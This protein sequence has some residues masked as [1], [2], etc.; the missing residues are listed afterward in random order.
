[1][2]LPVAAILCATAATYIL[3]ALAAGY[4]ARMGF[5]MPKD[6]RHVGCINGLRGYL[7]LS[8]L[9]H[10]F[11]IWILVSRTTGGWAPPPSPILA[12]FGSSSVA[13]FF[14]V[15]G[16]VFYPRVLDGWRNVAWKTL[17]T[18]RLFRIV[19]LTVVCV[20]VVV[21]IILARQ[22]M[23][24]RGPLLKPLSFW[25]TTIAEPDLLGYQYSKRI[26]AN[27]LWSLRCEW[28]FYF[29]LLPVCVLASSAARKYVSSLSICLFILG[30]L[31]AFRE[32]YPGTGFP[33]FAPLFPIGMLGYEIQSRPKWREVL[34]SRHASY[35]S[36]SVLA[37]SLCLQPHSTVQ[38]L[39]LSTFFFCV[40]CGNDYF[41]VLRRPGSLVLGESSFSIYMIHAIILSIVFTE[42]QLGAADFATG[43]LPVWLPLIALLV[44][45]VSQASYL[46]IERPAIGAGKAASA[47][48]YGRRPKLAEAELEVAP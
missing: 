12:N 7:A 2:E 46:I 32:V 45:L 3:C 24:A 11:S 38:L 5:P 27:V 10:H 43:W 34:S 15:T 42:G 30:A 26:N 22:G 9:V 44:S 19:P 41:G 16:F 14:M 25:L 28:I 35:A 18:A 36:L 8:V 23:Q 37:L 39:G 17:Y 13:L 31:L 6:S 29:G 1:M 47:Y 40:A 33:Q 20:L 48:L 4:V 21:I